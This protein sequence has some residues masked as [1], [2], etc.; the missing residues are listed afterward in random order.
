[1]KSTQR[2]G[3]APCTEGGAG[4]VPDGEETFKNVL[5]IGPVIVNESE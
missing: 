5:L 2:T 1:V 3:L 4:Y